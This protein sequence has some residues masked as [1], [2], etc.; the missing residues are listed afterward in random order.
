VAGA[1]SPLGC[2]LAAVVA[3]IAV[4][5]VVGHGLHVQRNP[6][7]GRVGGLRGVAATV[8]LVGYVVAYSTVLVEGLR[9]ALAH[10]LILRGAVRFDLIAQHGSADQACAGGGCAPTA[11]PYRIADQAACDS[12]DHGTCSAG[13]R[14]N[15]YLLV[16]TNLLWHS[17]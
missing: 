9:A 11:T 7:A 5:R 3:V 6:L 13:T 1:V 4:D 15:G 8:V 14:S 12:A 2:S 17:H 16:V 10:G